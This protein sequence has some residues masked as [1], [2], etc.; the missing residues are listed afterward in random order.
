M[1]RY[2]LFAIFCCTSLNAWGALS[3][4]DKA[5]IEHENLL[6]NPSFVHGRAAWLLSTGSFSVAGSGRDARASWDATGT[7]Q[8]L[9]SRAVAIP[10]RLHNQNGYF[11]VLTET[12]GT[13]TH[14]VRVYTGSSDLVEVD[15]ISGAEPTVTSGNFVYPN[16]GSL[17]LCIESQADEPALLVFSGFMGDALNLTN[18]SQAEYVGS[19]SYSAANNCRWITSNNNT[20]TDFPADVD[21]GTP[22]VTGSVQ[23]PGNNKPELTIDTKPGTYRF[24]ATGAHETTSASVSCGFKFSD[25]TNSSSRNGAY[26]GSGQSYHPSIEGSITYQTGGTRTINVQATGLGGAAGCSI[27][28][29]NAS[30]DLDYT[31]E[32]YYYPLQSQLAQKADTV[33]WFVDANLGGASVSFPSGAVSTY[34]EATN[35]GLTLTNNTNK[36][37]INAEVACASG[38][39]SEPGTCSSSNESVGIAFD[40][41]RAGLVEVCTNFSMRIGVLVTSSA[42]TFQLMETNNTDTTILQEGHGRNI[43]GGNEPNNNEVD[44]LP[45]TVCGTF[46][47]AS[48]GKKTIRLMYEKIA[49]TGTAQMYIGQ[50]ATLGDYDMHWT[51]RPIDQA[52]PAPLIK[53]SVVTSS[54]GVEGIERARI[55]NNG[56]PTVSS[57]SGDWINS[58][59]DNGVGRTTVNIKAGTFSETPSCQC[60]PFNGSVIRVCQITAQSSSAVSF[61]TWNQ[62]GV[63]T[64]IAF[65]LICM[66]PR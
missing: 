11:K 10:N 46:R 36:A 45:Q 51:A 42:F 6:E 44:Y 65:N 63:Y 5:F 53:Q 18:V 7:G 55:A 35:A 56:T 3:E 66:G 26:A 4:V 43:T 57:Q 16:S 13:A 15:L 21:C 64:D 27:I 17:Q 60:Q 19:L 28:N 59:T 14:T 33:N 20:Y 22:T 62:S 23:D 37:T 12:A 8:S 31:I 39:A 32:V 30:S 29:Q 24:V 41:P 34:A 61:T 9:C 25:G 47:F 49:H 1:M 40:V 54:E 58:L 50:G 2:L 38:N 52:S 48:K